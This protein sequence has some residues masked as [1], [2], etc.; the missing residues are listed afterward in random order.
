MA[1]GEGEA[2]RRALAGGGGSFALVFDTLRVDLADLVDLTDLADLAEIKA[3][4][5]QVLKIT[6]KVDSA[7]TKIK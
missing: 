5:E 4:K 1:K 7:K 3:L 6:P 2:A